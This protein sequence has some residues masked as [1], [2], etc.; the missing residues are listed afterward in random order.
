VVIAA[1][2]GVGLVAGSAQAATITYNLTLQDT[3]PGGISG[4]GTLT[5]AAPLLANNVYTPGPAVT[6]LDFV[7]NAQDFNE[8]STF[9]SIHTNASAQ[10]DAIT[11]LVFSPGFLSTGAL[12]FTYSGN[13]QFGSGVINLVA[14]ADGENEAAATPLPAALPLFAT[15]LGAMGLF[16][17]RRK[18]K[19]AVAAA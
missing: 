2:F 10:I 4:T 7:I 16:G 13:G 11:T 17:W 3:T 8:T 14:A 1:M 9:T 18:R 6:L 5:I 15:G 12:T 19:Q